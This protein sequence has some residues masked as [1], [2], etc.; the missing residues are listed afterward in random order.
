[1]KLFSFS[2]N[3]ESEPRR[4]KRTFIE[5]SEE[6]WSLVRDRLFSLFQDGMAILTAVHD[7]GRFFV[8]CQNLPEH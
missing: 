7:L 3:I 5:I 8:I 6:E 2:E 1:M 4:T